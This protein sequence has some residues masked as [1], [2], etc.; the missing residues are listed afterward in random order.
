M[1]VLYVAVETAAL[2]I[3]SEA[4]DAADEASVLHQ[5]LVGRVV[6]PQLTEGVDDDAKDQVQQ[7]CNH[8]DVV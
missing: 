4:I 8:D 1:V 2:G 5:A 7:D 6:A 3:E